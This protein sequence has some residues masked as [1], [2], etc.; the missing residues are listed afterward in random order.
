MGHLGPSEE[1]K[2]TLPS[3]AEGPGRGLTGRSARNGFGTAEIKGKCRCAL[4]APIE[5][6][7]PLRSFALTGPGPEKIE[8]MQI[9]RSEAAPSGAGEMVLGLVPSPIGNARHPRC[10]YNASDPR[11]NPVET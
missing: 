4:T 3:T 7:E 5:A 9:E 1:P 11:P 8:I 2:A 10:W 6:G